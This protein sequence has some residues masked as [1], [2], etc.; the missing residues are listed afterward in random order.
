MSKRR[1][2]RRPLS[3]ADASVLYRSLDNQQSAEAVRREVLRSKIKMSELDW[4]GW[5]YIVG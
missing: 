5:Q 1:A 2:E 4:H 3:A